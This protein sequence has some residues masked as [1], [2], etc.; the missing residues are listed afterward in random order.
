MK[1]LVPVI[2]VI[3]MLFASVSLLSSCT[4]EPI[5]TVPSYLSVSVVQQPSGGQN[6][7]TLTAKYTFQYRFD[8]TNDSEKGWLGLDGKKAEE[9]K[10][11]RLTILWINDKGSTYN[12]QDMYISS[13][14]ATGPYTTT[15]STPEKGLFF[16]KTF[17]ARFSWM[18]NNGRHELDSNKVACTVK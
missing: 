11:I 18:D 17:W 5:E 2:L 10:D 16:D 12:Q 3:I 6:V 9:P 14:T 7:S 13:V 1:R 15:V 8:G 4:C